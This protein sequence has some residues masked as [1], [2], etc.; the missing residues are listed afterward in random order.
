MRS[1]GKELWSENK[2]NNKDNKDLKSE[3]K[4]KNLKSEYNDMDKDLQI[5]KQH[6]RRTTEH[7]DHLQDTSTRNIQRIYR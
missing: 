3:D 2:D 7:C 6:H 5:G 1:K 4:D